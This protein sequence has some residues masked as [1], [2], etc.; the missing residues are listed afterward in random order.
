MKII[1]K[2]K[3]LFKRDTVAVEAEKKDPAVK[4]IRK[5]FWNRI[6]RNVATVAVLMSDL[7]GEVKILS[8]IAIWTTAIAHY[9]L[10]KAEYRNQ[11][12]NIY[13]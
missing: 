5:L 7:S 2:I 11:V 4:C 1:V 3:N 10:S 8:L 6:I 12:G 13:I 9:E